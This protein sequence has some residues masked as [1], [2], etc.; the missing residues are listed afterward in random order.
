MMAGKR[1]GWR[2]RCEQICAGAKVS[3]GG[4]MIFQAAIQSGVI[5]FCTKAAICQR[6]GHNPA[7]KMTTRRSQTKRRRS[8]QHG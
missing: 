8:E 6:T 2:Q 4:A 7:P 1:N 5:Q 3:N